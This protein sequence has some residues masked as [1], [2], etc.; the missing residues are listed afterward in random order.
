MT[1]T[2][3]PREFHAR[4]KVSL[5][6]F[7]IVMFVVVGVGVMYLWNWLIP[8]IF[9]LRTI[10][11]FQAVGLLILSRVLFG[12]F[13]GRHGRPPRWAGMSPEEGARFREAMVQHLNRKYSAN[14]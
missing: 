8:A 10:T 9:G 5:L 12:G 11:Y 2:P 3:L 6:V 13:P 14:G 1:E 7:S 4:R